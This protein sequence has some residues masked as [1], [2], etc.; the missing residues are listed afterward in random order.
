[1]KV[2][3]RAIASLLMVLCL[4]FQAVAQ[5]PL[6]SPEEFTA[7]YVQELQKRAPELKIR[8]VEPLHVKLGDGL[9]AYLDSTFTHYKGNPAGRDKIVADY[10]TATLETI[11]WRG[12]RVDVSR[13]V[14]VIKD[15][16]YLEEVR[17]N[18]RNRRGR[19]LEPSYARDQYNSNLV[20]LYAEDTPLNIRYLGE[21]DLVE[22]GFKKEKR[23][24]KA[25]DNLR[26]LLPKIQV[27]GENGTFSITAGGIYE[28]S[29][30]LFDHIWRS[31]Q[32]KVKGELVVAIPTRG[33]LLV[34]GSKDDKGLAYVRRTVA[35]AMKS[36]SYNLT[37]RLF[38]Y[39]KG[40]FVPFSR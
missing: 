8:T 29:L 13:I 24:I 4:A 37:N 16:G 7:L 40:R 35:K 28:S 21:E 34:T 25:I 31:G 15:L 36:G 20:I 1:M 39:R 3:V 14:P 2:V 33:V 19:K 22:V 10:V 17:N 12:K 38:V 27:H 26:A 32:W 30:L 6:L 5:S 11:H 18:L 9:T 23:R